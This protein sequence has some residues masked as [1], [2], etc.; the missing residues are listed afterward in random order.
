MDA[1]AIRSDMSS[2]TRSVRPLQTTQRGLER[3][4]EFED[5]PHLGSLIG[6]AYCP[7][8]T[9]RA[10]HRFSHSFSHQPAGTVGQSTVDENK[11]Q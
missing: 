5:D 10:E 9:T 8:V 6:G 1:G 11:L 2:P 3:Q 7:P 4:M